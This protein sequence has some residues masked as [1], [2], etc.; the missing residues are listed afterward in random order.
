MS[1]WAQNHSIATDQ[2]DIL[3]GTS[4]TTQQSQL[5]SLNQEHQQFKVRP[6]KSRATLRGSYPPLDLNQPS[7]ST[8][9]DDRSMAIHLAGRK[10]ESQTA[11]VTPKLSR[12]V[13][14]REAESLTSVRMEPVGMFNSEVGTVNIQ[15]VK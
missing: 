14:F 4:T 6:F 13:S 3:Q 15:T 9:L 1:L 8:R 12:D 7:A 5:G 11:A 10:L 2:Q